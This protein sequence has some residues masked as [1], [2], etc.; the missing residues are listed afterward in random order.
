MHG[1]KIDWIAELR[2]QSFKPRLASYFQVDWQFP[3][4]EL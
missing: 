4:Q 3:I 2:P 1:I